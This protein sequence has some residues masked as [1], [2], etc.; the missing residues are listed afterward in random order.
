[1]S[2]RSLPCGA[3]AGLVVASA[4]L[5]GCAHH[6]PRTERSYSAISVCSLLDSADTHVGREVTVYGTYRYGFEWQDLYCV[7]CAGTRDGFVWIEFEE[8]AEWPTGQHFSRDQGSFNVVFRGQFDTGTTYGHEN[9][10]RSQLRVSRI[11]D[12]RFVGSS[13]AVPAALP[14]EMRDKVCPR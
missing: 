14:Q 7:R 4:L 10:Y 6:A 13:G 12:A 3:F 8:E 2:D 9:G 5:L 1:M 11:I